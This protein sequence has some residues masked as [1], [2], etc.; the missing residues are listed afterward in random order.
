MDIRG[1]KGEEDDAEGNIWIQEG[2]NERRT[3]LEAMFGPKREE[4]REG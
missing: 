3:L 1:K 2:R 4:V